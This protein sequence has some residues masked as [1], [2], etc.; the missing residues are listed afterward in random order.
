MPSTTT[1]RQRLAARS[2]AGSTFALRRIHLDTC[3]PR[4]DYRKLC[5]KRTDQILASGR[6]S[7]GRLCVPPRCTR[8]QN[9]SDQ[10]SE[11]PQRSARG[12]KYQ[13]DRSRRSHPDLSKPSTA[14]SGL[15]SIR[16]RALAWT[17]DRLPLRESHYHHTRANRQK[18][19]HSG[20]SWRRSG[21]WIR[22][23]VRAASGQPPRKPLKKCAESSHVHFSSLRTDRVTATGPVRSPL[24]AA[25]GNSEIVVSLAVMNSRRAGVPF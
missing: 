7:Y 9:K 17:R 11:V 20:F 19:K 10:R 15:R 18:G 6:V 22:S 3:S 12:R 1:Q 8:L 16:L 2:R 21:V 25:Q 5:Q 4:R 14:T 24:L 13:D 23:S